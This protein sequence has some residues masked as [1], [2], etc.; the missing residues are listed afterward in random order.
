[1]LLFF[2]ASFVSFE[3]PDMPTP[4]LESAP[5]L[6]AQ[7]LPGGRC[8][9]RVWAPASAR[10]DLHLLGPADRVIPM[11]RGDR[12]YHDV[13]ANACPPGA[14]YL[15]RLD[16]GRERPDP[17]SRLQ[18]RGVHGPSQVVDDAF[19]W[20][21]AGW[22]GLPLPRAVFYELHVG[23]FTP[24]GTF[25]A[26]IP[27][28]AGLRDLGVTAVEIMPV[29]QFPGTRNWGYDGVYPFAVQDAYGGPAGLRRL[30]DACHAAGLAVALDVVYNHLGPEG[31][32]L[33]D[34]GPY[35][36][37]RYHTPWGSPINFDGPGSDEV[38]RYFVENAVQWV[39]D[40]H[41]DALRLDA[42]HAIF[43]FTA[44]PF[45][46]DV[47]EAVHG[48]AA[49]L[50][51]PAY[52]IAENS[53]N[54]ARLIR[55]PA[56]GGYGLDAQWSDDLHH[57][58]HVLLT[59]ERGGYYDDFAAGTL[60]LLARAYRHGFAY[61]GEY[62]AFRGRRH[63]GATW[64]CRA[65]QF[66]VCAQ[67]HDQVGNRARSDRL[68]TLVPFEALKLAAGTVILSPF[69]PLLFMG[70][71][72]GERAPFLY[73]ISHG[74]PALV[75]AVRKGRREE[76]AAFAW[77]G[78]LPDPQSEETLARS[79]I[80]PELYAEGEGAALKAF[81]RELLRLRRAWAPLA[82]PD[83]ETQVVESLEAE[84]ALVVR[85]RKGDEEIL[86]LLHFQAAPAGVTLDFAPG[87]WRKLLDSADT[88]WAGP[89]VSLPDPIHST[90]RATFSLAPWSVA[91]YGRTL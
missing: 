53:L 74:D 5:R 62:S 30:V 79:R 32:Y 51:R 7:I 59:G 49:R 46:Q 35:F 24:E 85:R 31:N 76:F 80:R 58:L 77:A 12:G 91:V 16:G 45:L 3:V 84:R 83:L 64:G 82:E 90:G 44:R 8:R 18:P 42:V 4:T 70:E 50:G 75:E 26:V 73:F 57:A 66:V 61:Q 14:L 29:A 28:L 56:L 60:G 6:G 86:G 36:S 41:M 19:A 2:F 38:R 39:T 71:E 87:D 1:M 21:D 68:S 40:F 10:V 78:E 52:V 13:V 89:G 11:A 48:E 65:S 81:Y 55:P 20:T 63:G 69:L 23:T 54:D 43:D 37:G 33:G 88:R 27:R 47:A 34:F 15:Y 9:F 72:Y 22:R 67:D 25:D 17:A